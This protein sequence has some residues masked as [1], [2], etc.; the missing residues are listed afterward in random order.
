MKNIKKIH[1]IVPAL[2]LAGSMNP[3]KLAL[4]EE[5]QKVKE[6]EEIVVSAE[7]GA[8]VLCYPRLIP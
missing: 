8:R 1:W 2:L 7:S 6:L 5:Q 4:A 3:C